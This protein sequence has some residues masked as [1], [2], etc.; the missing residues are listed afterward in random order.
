MMATLN[1]RSVRS[2]LLVLLSMTSLRTACGQPSLCYTE[3]SADTVVVST[4]TALANAVNNAPPGRNILVAPGTY[5]A[6]TLTFTGS[7]TASNPVV[8]RPQNGIGTVTFNGA[9]WAI[10]GSR[11]VFSGL[12]FNNA[13]LSLDNGASFNRIT[14]CRFR[15]IGGIAI[16]LFAA[17]DTRIDHCDFANYLNNENAKGCIRFR[18]TNVG[19]GTLKRVLIDYCYFHDMSTT[20]GANG[21]EPVGQ[22][23]SAGG[24]M[25]A[26]PEVVIDHCLFRNIGPI[27]GEGEILGT[28]SRGWKV[29]YT[30]FENINSMYLNFPRVGT[31]M[32]ARSC[33]FEG[34][35]NP[36]LQGMSDNLT[37]IGCRFA[38]GEHL[39]VFAG[40]TKWETWV[41]DGTTTPSTYTPVRNGKIIG[42][43]LDTGQI[44]V[45][46]FWSNL[47]ATEPVQNTLLAANT[48]NGAPATTSN[49][50]NLIYQTGTTIGATTS[51]SF[52]PAVK[53]APADVGLSA[54]DPLCSGGG[55]GGTV[56]FSDT[57]SYPNGAPPSNYWSEGN[58]ASIQ[59]GQLY[60]NAN[61]GAHNASTIWLNQ[62]FSGDLRIEYDAHVISS[63]T[64]KINNI[65]HFVLFSD[66][67]GT[68]LYDTRAGRS[69]GAY[70]KYHSLNGYI[71]TYVNDK[72]SAE[73]PPARFRLRDVP[74]FSNLLQEA[75]TYNAAGG[76]TRHVVIEK[77]GNRITYRVDGVLALDKVD[78]QFNPAHNSGL[79][80]FRTAATELWYDN[81]VVTSLSGGGPAT[82]VGHWQL[83]EASGNS[84][85]DSSGN[86][87]HG[88][89]SNGPAWTTGQ[90]GN[91]LSFDG[92][93]DV[94]NCGSGAS[95]DNLPSIS[96]SA[97][98]NPASMGEG[99]F[100]RIASKAVDPTFNSGWH[101]M[102]AGT[103]QL[104]FSARHATTNVQRRTNPNSIATGAWQ[105]VAVTWDGSTTATNVRIYVNGVEVS[106][107][108][109]TTNGSGSR[110]DDADSNLY[111]GNNSG[112]A[113]TFHGVLDDV[114]VYNGVLGASEIAD[115]YVA[116]VTPP[117]IITTSLPSGRTTIG[118]GSQQLAATGGVTPYTWSVSAG[119]LP[120]G[121]SLSGGGVVSGTPTTAGTSNFTARV[122]DAGS[123]TDD[124]PLAITINANSIP[125]ITTTSLPGGTVGVGYNQSVASTGGDVALLWSVAG[126]SLPAGLALANVNSQDAIISGTPTTEG[127]SNFTLKLQDVDA[128]SD[129]QALSISISVPPPGSFTLSSPDNGTTGVATLPTLNWTDASGATGYN[130]IVDDSSDFGSPV[131][132]QTGLA[133]SQYTV[134]SA[135]ANNTTYYWKVTA[136]NA[137]GSTPASNNNFSF[138]TESGASP[139]ALVGHW[140]LDETSGGAAADSSGNANTG[141]LGNNP[142]WT[143]GQAG[144]GLSFDGVD[145]IVN[146]GSG[147][148]LDNLA[149]ITAAAWIKPTDMG[150]GGFGRIVVKNANGTAGWE[151]MTSA[152]NQL[153]FNVDYATTDLK[154]R[155]NANTIAT[156]VWQHVAVTWDGS[157]TAA[158]ARVY[159]NGAEVGYDITTNAAGARVND[160]TSNLYLGNLADT[161][162]TFK[163]VLDDV[164][165]YNG[166]LSA[167][168]ILAIYQAGL[169]YPLAPS[170]LSATAVGSSQINLG[171]TDNS[172]NETGFKI[173]R[174]TGAGGTYAQVDTTAAGANSYNDTGLTASTTYYH[175]VR[176]TNASG[177]SAYS[178]EASAT[179]TAAGGSIAFRAASQA[180]G[181]GTTSLVIN[182]PAGVLS[183]DFMLAG[184]SINKSSSSDPAITAPSGWSL[185]RSLPDGLVR[186]SVYRRTAGSSEP[187]SYTWTISSAV[188]VAGGIAAY[189]GVNT[190]TPIQLENGA[191]EGTTDTT[192][193]TT[194]TI[195]TTGS[196]TWLVSIFGDR[197]GTTSSTWTPPSGATERVDVRTT[198]GTSPN[199]SLSIHDQG[200]VTAGNKAHTATA[201][202]SSKDAAMEIIAIQP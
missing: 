46:N 151:F 175:R 71:I 13:R 176:A 80:G 133:G 190:T 127:T 66:S 132:N 157:T 163:G 160:G 5:N 104:T 195:T 165:V 63:N 125:D 117:D 60:V 40:N 143:A 10:H 35:R 115:L 130:L 194:P 34:G 53:L 54:P 119:S 58:A 101:F 173:E 91:G 88:M 70:A 191:V 154:R 121:L 126:G 51:E 179:T 12:Y 93:D 32:E 44:R 170:G 177:D 178:N 50:I 198:Q 64:D 123:Q 19:N 72:G 128:D 28:K 186:T 108:D 33:W 120:A 110:A 100:G 174:K 153:T 106:G 197:T 147:T 43:V 98:I 155:T 94:V 86:A 145:D 135:L 39:D 161:T 131:I 182:K 67:S 199:V 37:V 124:Q 3:S 23:S 27:H 105:H 172:N 113:R 137:G 150:E 107:Y 52:T 171:W 118:Y 166:I 25:F 200:P 97:W 85:A 188:R 114:R 69:D 84:A 159:V 65:N 55:S 16:Q 92:L 2:L 164:R 90:L 76:V 11:L 192:S 47:A 18:H 26:F 78:D 8:I 96:V 73:T 21:S 162:R 75:N 158:N 185:V 129:T 136:V 48:R 41:A 99:G 62:V 183:G 142:M 14:R 56:I 201:S 36:T 193:H 134:A 17:T 138:T 57:F 74:T 148:T 1:R 49:G 196:A 187:A 144:G 89:L 156:G 149:A 61:G 102:K 168:E 180:S 9:T 59:N 79:I 81:L 140:Q 87:N 7:G 30:T 6:A 146:C 109:V 111:L 95:L 103:D 68:P 42:N 152:T 83:N 184:I 202:V 31:D 116:G 45:G 4:T 181:S 24:A 38:G 112:G 15:E 189:S 82:L 29:Q 22:T 20:V 77:I 169:G 122:T 167:S 139:A 141:T